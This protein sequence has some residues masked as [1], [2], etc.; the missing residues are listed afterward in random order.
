MG[1]RAT[2]GVDVS[3]T[4]NNQLFEPPEPQPMF[5]GIDIRTKNQKKQKK[6][7]SREWR[8]L[9]KSTRRRN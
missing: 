5:K 3:T 8:K 6:A 4:N 1:P 9:A 7:I 2:G